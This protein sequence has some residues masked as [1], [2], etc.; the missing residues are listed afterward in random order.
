[1]QTSYRR[2]H[3]DRLRKSALLT[4]QDGSECQDWGRGFE[5]R[6]PLCSNTVSL[7]YL[8]LPGWLTATGYAGA[9]PQLR[10]GRCSPRTWRPG[11]TIASTGA[12]LGGAVPGSATPSAGL[13]G[14]GALGATGGVPAI[15]RGAAVV[16]GAGRRRRGESHL[17]GRGARG[18]SAARLPAGAPAGT[19]RAI[20]MT[21]S[22][23]HRIKPKTATSRTSARRCTREPRFI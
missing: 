4:N 2:T 14:G 20:T 22:S 3:P 1:M 10:S 18:P 23:W 12:I 11:S 9:G 7:I 13:L 5:S 8:R 21:C 17:R 16:A 15:G 6:L 19:G